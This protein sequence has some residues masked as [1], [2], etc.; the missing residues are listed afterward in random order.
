MNITFTLDGQDVPGVG[1]LDEV[2]IE[3]NF[4]GD[5]P[6]S[7][8]TTDNWEFVGDNAL[9][10]QSYI[11]NGSNGGLGIFFGLPFVMSLS[12]GTTTIDFDMFVDPSSEESLLSCDKMV[13]KSI[14]RES[15]QWLDDV[16]DSFTFEY[17]LEKT[18]VIDESDFTF[19]PYVISTVPNYRE[20][21]IAIIGLFVVVNELRDAIQRIAGYIAAAGNPL[22]SIG[23]IIKLILFVAYFI[24]VLIALVSLVTDLINLLIQPVK[25]HS[26]MYV[27]RLI[28]AGCEHLGLEFESTIF[29]DDNW[30]N[31]FL[32][33]QKYANP[34]DAADNKILGFLFPDT[35]VQKG[36]PKGTFGDLLRN[37]SIMFNAKF[38]IRD[39]TLIFE[40]VDFLDLGVSGVYTIP[41]IEQRN[42]RTNAS[43]VDSTY[44]IE[45]ATDINDKNTIDE[46]EGTI[47]QVNTV[48][49]IP[50]DS[51]NST[52]RNSTTQAIP[53]AR[54]IKKVGLTTVEEVVSAA[55]TVISIVVNLFVTIGNV[56]V[57][58]ANA[59]GRLIKG[60]KR[61]L[62]L[63]GINLNVNIPDVPTIP[64]VSFGQIVAD[65]DCMLKLE[66]DF[67]NV[68]K[69][70]I[71]REGGAGARSNRLDDNNDTIVSA[72]NLWD[73]FHNINGF[74]PNEGHEPNQ[75]IRKELTGVPF[76]FQNFLDVRNN[77]KILT[78]DGLEAK[79]ES[80]TWNPST[81]VAD[82]RYRYRETYTTNLKEEKIIPDGR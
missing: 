5:S 57:T 34:P 13:L 1:N 50:G 35:A 78:H 54:G 8:V 19:V 25:Y 70:F 39:G 36:V 69:L 58:L 27:K 65:R 23:E 72:E 37:M 3:L 66:N 32:L 14:E 11:E 71:L 75:W 44:L 17:L 80:L 73:E 82:M 42:Y 51:K 59:L 33:P 18:N 46:Y 22:Q 47:I 7:S 56:V 2:Q 61:V 4:D 48:P 9:Q 52:L 38:V 16:A 79:I 41:P 15:V 55:L 45:F 76:S 28:E 63:V 21:I 40:R 20:T 30:K 26:G 49:T 67:V 53:Y 60:L 77:V 43:E 68:E 6:E 62:N 74:A 81:K 10:V 29:D 12:D 64:F 31:L 24:G